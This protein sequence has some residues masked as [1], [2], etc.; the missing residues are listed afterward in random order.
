MSASSAL[1]AAR[2]RRGGT[3]D[4]STNKN[5]N[6]TQNNSTVNTQQSS[7]NSNEPIHPFV[8]LKKHDYIINKHEHQIKMLLENGL[9]QSNLT[10]Q[11]IQ[12]AMT[13]VNLPEITTNVLKQIEEQIDFRVFYENDANLSKELEQLNNLVRSQQV[14]INSLQTIIN[15]LVSQL[16][17]ERCEDLIEMENKKEVKIDE[18]KNEISEFSDNDESIANYVP[19]ENNI[20]MKLGEND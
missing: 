1:A 16:N 9:P 7:L 19:I 20:E 2:R 13:N 11:P 4:K 14:T 12:T 8:L 15:H 10:S 17:L 18:T 5:T 6:S 3:S